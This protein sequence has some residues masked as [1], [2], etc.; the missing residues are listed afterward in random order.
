MKI[1]ETRYFLT[2]FIFRFFE[3]TKFMT[4]ILIFVKNA[5]PDIHIVH[6][7]PENDYTDSKVMKLIILNMDEHIPS[8]QTVMKDF[9]IKMVNVFS[10][11]EKI[12]LRNSKFE[13]MSI[14]LLFQIIQD[15]FRSRF[16][17]QIRERIWGRCEICSECLEEIRLFKGEKPYNLMSIF[18]AEDISDLNLNMIKGC[19]VF[20]NHRH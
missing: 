18:S 19:A 16:G 4:E 1:I 10:F 15:H 11:F 7:I 6:E 2:F 9:K 3:K 5:E 20:K 13:K 8:F 12:F 17:K 14:F